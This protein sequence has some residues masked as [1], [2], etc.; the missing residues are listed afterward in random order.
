MSWLLL[1][2]LFDLYFFINMTDTNSTN[3]KRKAELP[4]TMMT[5]LISG[6]V[7]WIP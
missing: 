6:N 1:F 3:R 5:G 4:V 7:D 2:V